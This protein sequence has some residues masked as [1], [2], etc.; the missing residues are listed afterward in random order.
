MEWIDA[1]EAARM[2]NVTSKTIKN[3]IERGLLRGRKVNDQHRTS[4]Y[5]VERKSVL[6]FM[7]NQA[8]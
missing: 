3:Y 8:K 6:E 2:L 7:R 5:L 1:Q 4:P